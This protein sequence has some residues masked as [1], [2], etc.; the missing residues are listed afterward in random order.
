MLAV[1][2]F[3]SLYKTVDGCQ[4]FNQSAF[5]TICIHERPELMPFTGGYNETG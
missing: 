1:L 4:I 5:F 3:Q 2:Q